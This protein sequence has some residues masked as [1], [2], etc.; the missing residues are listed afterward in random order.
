MKSLTTSAQWFM[1]YSAISFAASLLVLLGVCKI[2]AEKQVAAEPVVAVASFT[3]T[4]LDYNLT[5]Q[6]RRFM[7]EQLK[8]RGKLQVIDSAKYN[9]ILKAKGLTEDASCATAACGT[10]LGKSLGADIVLMGT[11]EQSDFEY[12]VRVFIVDVNK[13]TIQQKLMH[14]SSDSWKDCMDEMQT[15][16]DRVNASIPVTASAASQN[17]PNKNRKYGWWGLLGGTAAVS[18]VVVAVTMASQ[19]R[20]QESPNANMDVVMEW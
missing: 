16:T 18:A 17:I 3:S 8:I 1:K 20:K 7:L 15:I 5:D 13:G 9:S 12:V 14:S 11:V 6:A 19:N 2:S 4:N 10:V